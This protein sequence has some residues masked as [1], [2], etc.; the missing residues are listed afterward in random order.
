MLGSRLESLPNVLF[1]TFP[2]AGSDGLVAL[3]VWRFV[4]VLEAGEVVNPIGKY[5]ATTLCV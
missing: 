2:H 1:C 5:V 4:L 3:G